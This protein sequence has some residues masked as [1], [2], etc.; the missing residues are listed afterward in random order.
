[1]RFSEFSDSSAAYSSYL[2]LWWRPSQ[3][4]WRSARSRDLLELLEETLTK[5]LALDELVTHV[6]RVSR[7][8]LTPKIRQIV[9]QH[10]TQRNGFLVGKLETHRILLFG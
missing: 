3:R 1:M 2:A 4:F 6:A 7:R 9:M 10:G 5:I 8:N